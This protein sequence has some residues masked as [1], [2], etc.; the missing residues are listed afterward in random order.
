VTTDNRVQN[1]RWVTHKENSNNEL[2]LKHK[3]NVYK[4]RKISEEHKEKL[5][6][7]SKNRRKVMCIETGIIYSSINEAA[8]NTNVNSGTI[9]KCCKGIKKSGGGYHWK[10]VKSN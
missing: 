10:Y 1:L 6:E 5:K 3:S 9:C 2:T 4:G 8:R 7:A